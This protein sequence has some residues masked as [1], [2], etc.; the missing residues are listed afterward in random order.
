[1]LTFTLTA[2]CAAAAGVAVAGEEAK[3]AGWPR[4][5]TGGGVALA[6]EAKAL[7]PGVAGGAIVG[8]RGLAGDVKGEAV[9][10]VL[11]LTVRETEALG[12]PTWAAD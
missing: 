12:E 4:G 7:E 11:E 5:G 6:P 3:E 8:V 1:M 9:G 10:A 2:L